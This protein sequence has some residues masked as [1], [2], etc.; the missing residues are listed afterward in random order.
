MA[1][2]I[3]AKMVFGAV[4]QHIPSL[5]SKAIDDEKVSKIA[6]TV[7][8]AA[9]GYVADKHDLHLSKEDAWNKVKDDETFIKS[10]ESE[11]FKILEMETQDI[12]HAR[13]HTMNE[14]T[15][16]L[17]RHV[18]AW[19]PLYILVC[20]CLIVSAPIVFADPVIV[21]AVTGPAGAALGSFF[22]ERQ[23]VYAYIFGS[24]IG[25]KLKGMKKL[26]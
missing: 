14:H 1:L 12:Q 26:L 15:M 9:V 11:I 21:A 7:T 19:S 23:Q 24:S 20:L 3:L 17:A 2:P 16:S 18:L 5:I 10:Q 6:E 25:S 13:E 22:Q 4:A 8:G